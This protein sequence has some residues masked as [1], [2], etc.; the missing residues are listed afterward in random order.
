MFGWGGDNV[1]IND[2]FFKG[3]STFRG[4]DVS[5]I[6]PRNILTYTDDATGAVTDVING[7]SLG[8]KLYSIGTLQLEVPT[9]LPKEYGIGAA[10]FTEFG[11]VGLL[12]K[13]DKRTVVIDGRHD[14]P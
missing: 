11:T 8:G 7:D 12:D 1:R 5:G 6:G 10:L 3:G 13:A 4:F 14:N 2:R 9:F